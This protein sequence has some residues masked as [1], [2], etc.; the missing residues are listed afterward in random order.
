MEG[1]QMWSSL[2]RDVGMVLKGRGGR[3]ER[4]EA[5]DGVGIDLLSSGEYLCS[6]P[7]PT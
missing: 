3:Q 5:A 4:L 2:L 1:Q 7:P 6:P